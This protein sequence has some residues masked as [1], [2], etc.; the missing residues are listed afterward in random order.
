MALVVIGGVA[1]G[2]ER[3]RPR[4][5]DSIRAWKSWSSKKGPVIS[6]GACGLPYLVEG[7]VRRRE[8]ADRLHSRVF[9]QGAPH[10]SAHR[11]AG[12]LDGPCAA[13]GAAGIGRAGAV[14]APGAGH[15]RAL[16][17]AGALPARNSRMYSRCT[18]W[19][20]PSACAP[21]CRKPAAAGGGDRRGL[22]RRGGGRCA[23]PQRA[24]R[25]GAG[26]IAATRCCATIRRSRGGAAVTGSARSG[27]ALRRSR[28]ESVGR[29]GWRACRATWW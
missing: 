12:G 20:M 7:R 24:A 6:Y 25:D 1:A 14:R 15:R 27:A 18:R 19:R 28:V 16:R 17:H 11:R 2:H 3:G 29:A 22:H 10:R 4:A 23:A 13:R 9:P 26:A 21:F 5:A 8:A